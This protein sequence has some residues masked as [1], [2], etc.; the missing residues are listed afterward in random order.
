MRYI[1]K[2]S[3]IAINYYTQRILL[4]RRYTVILVALLKRYYNTFF[5]RH[6]FPLCLDING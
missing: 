3:S 4:K 5:N 6:C 1:L 2:P